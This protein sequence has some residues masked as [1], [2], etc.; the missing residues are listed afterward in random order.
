MKI[1]DHL[2]DHLCSLSKLRFEG[3]DRVAL[4]SDLEKIIGFL[5]KLNSIDTEGVEPLIF[6]N[7]SRN[8][9]R[10]DEVK[11]EISKS[12]ALQNAPK[13]DSDYFRVSKVRGK[14]NA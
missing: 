5:D 9:L 13:K 12:E 4:K 7:A 2:I 6:M 3:Q 14:H 1:D 11:M 10:S 8:L